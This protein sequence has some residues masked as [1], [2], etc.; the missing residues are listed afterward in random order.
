M[1]DVMRYVGMLYGLL[2][3]VVVFGLMYVEDREYKLDLLRRNYAIVYRETNYCSD[4]I[5][6]ADK[7]LQRLRT[8]LYANN[9]LKEAEE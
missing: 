6:K 9:L 5:V 3:I 8:I 4:E 1:F 2:V 7:E